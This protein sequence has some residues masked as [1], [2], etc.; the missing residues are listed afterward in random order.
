LKGSWFLVK[1]I[2]KRNG[3]GKEEKPRAKPRKEKLFGGF[4]VHKQPR[5]E[6]KKKRRL[7]STGYFP[8]LG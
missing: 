6:Q 4:T 7:K 1:S 8:P 3:R 5:R 2:K